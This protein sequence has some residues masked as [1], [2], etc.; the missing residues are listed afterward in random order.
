MRYSIE[1]WTIKK[2]FETHKKG[3]LNLNPPYQRND[4]W[5]EKGQKDLISSIKNGM[6]IPNFFFHKR[7]LLKYDIADGQQRTRAILAYISKEITD[8]NEVF[9]DKESEF[10]NYLIPIV[11]INIDISEEEIRAFYVKVNNSGLRVNSPELIKSIHFNSKILEL[12]EE[13]TDL[14]S[15]KQLGIFSKKQEDRMIDREFV[16][17]LICQIEYGVGDKKNDIKRLYKEGITISDESIESIKDKFEKA[18]KICV[19]FDKNVKISETRYS[20]KNDFYTLFGFILNNLTLQQSTFNYFYSIL[21]KIELDVSPTN[22]K[23]EALQNYAYKC[24]SQSNSKSARQDRLNFFNLLFLNTSPIPNAIQKELIKYY[25]L[26]KN[27][28]KKVDK[29]YTLDSELIQSKFIDE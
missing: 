3:N 5:L 9:F 4:I 16:E 25:V 11:V 15:F 27:G 17:E 26:P 6:P 13:L 14:D 7:S 24:V 28:F 20:Q 10:L 8:A 23:C 18:L 21:I 2:L 22:E 12:A 1:K 19:A 29:F